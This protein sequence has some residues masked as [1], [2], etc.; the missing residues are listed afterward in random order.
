[1]INTPAITKRRIVSLVP[2]ITELLFALDLE[3]EVVGITKFCIY[4][5]KWFRTKTRIGGTKT[6]NIEQIALLQPHLIIANKEENVKEQ[7]EQLAASFE[8]LVTDVN[9]F[10]QALEMIR[11]VGLHANRADKAEILATS[12]KD[13]FASLRPAPLQPI[14][15]FI[16]KD[17]WMT[18]GGDTFINDMLL[19]A[20][21][22]NRFAHQS[23][24]PTIA[25]EDLR[26]LGACK[27]LLSS[28]PYPF[29][30]K[31]AAALKQ[32]L[33]DAAILLVDGTLFS[34][35]GSRMLQAPSYFRKLNPLL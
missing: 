28:E 8:V 24:Y 22:S 20:G 3:E 25:L 7:V 9:N 35:Y 4:P 32:L 16:W 10:D 19:K 13:S 21:F 33:P 26:H 17:P 11:Q 23:R 12:I 30:E 6:I 31:H 1:M 14:V 29:K 27:I 5:E 34:W 15:Y 2:S 18:V